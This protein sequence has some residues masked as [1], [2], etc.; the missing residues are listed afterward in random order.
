VA[1][2]PLVD[3]VGEADTR[4]LIDLLRPVQAALIDAGAFARLRGVSADS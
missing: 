2:A 3:A 1:S 4:R